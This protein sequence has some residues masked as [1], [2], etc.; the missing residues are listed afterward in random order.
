MG[1]MIDC[2]SVCRFEWW[3]AYNIYQIYGCWTWPATPWNTSRT[4]VDCR[5]SLNLTSD[6]TTSAPPSVNDDYLSHLLLLVPVAASRRVSSHLPQWQ[7]VIP[8]ASSFSSRFT[9][10]SISQLISVIIPTLVIHH[11]FTLSLQAQ[12]LPF[13]EILSTVDFFYLLDCLTIMGLDW[14]Y[15]AHHFVFSFTF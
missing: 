4:W 3:K 10:S 2:V 13:Q 12:N 6:A 1:S 15:H 11:F 8:S 9:S 5:R 7:S 14:I